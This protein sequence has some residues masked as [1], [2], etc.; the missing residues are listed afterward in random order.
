[1]DPTQVQ[2]PAAAPT[3]YVHSE[4]DSDLDCEREEREDWEKME[5][6]EELVQVQDCKTTTNRWVIVLMLLLWV[7]TTILLLYMY[8]IIFQVYLHCT[9]IV[10]V[11]KH[12]EQ[13]PPSTYMLVKQ[14][15]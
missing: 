15:L 3:T 4:S 1:M 5:K 9:E 10:H 13:E 11:L 6:Q 7:L 12:M 2:P 14:E 8:R